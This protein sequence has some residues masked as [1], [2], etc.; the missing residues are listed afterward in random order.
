M[1]TELIPFD[2]EVDLVGRLGLLTSDELLEEESEV[3][4]LLTILI[5]FL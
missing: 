3:R 2:A 4:T 1:C 5:F